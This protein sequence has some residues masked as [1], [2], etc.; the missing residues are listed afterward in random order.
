MSDITVNLKSFQSECVVGE[1]EQPLLC[2]KSRSKGLMVNAC[3]HAVFFC[4]LL[5]AL[6][7]KEESGKV[8]LI[9]SK[10]SMGGEGLKVGIIGGGHAGKQ[11]AR[12]LLELS[13]I[14]VQNI[15]ISTRRPETLSEFQQLGVEC[16]YDNG[17]LVAWAEVVFLCCLP[18]HLLHVCSGIHAALREPCIVYSLVT[19]VPLPRLKQLLSYSAILRP[20][21]QCTSRDL[22]NEWR[23]N[24]TIRAVLQDP[25]VIQATCPCSPKER[26]AVTGKW[27]EAVFYAALNSCMRW[28]LPHQQALKLLND[29]CFP[30]HCPICA[31]Q[32]TS[33]P[34][35]V[36]ENFVNQTFASSL[37]QE[38]T[39]PW[40]DLITVQLKES[41]FSQLLARSVLLQNH[42][43]LLYCTS[44]GFLLAKSGGMASSGIWQQDVS[45]S[46]CS[47]SQLDHESMS[48]TTAIDGT[49][50]EDPRDGPNTDSEASDNI[51][52]V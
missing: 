37:T 50:T 44:F 11:L 1:S 48:T 51:T 27:L 3:A 45:S 43:T 33:C 6:R 32:Q 7:Q 49:R 47:R 26:I 23:T 36:C 10:E 5:Q 31:E 52:V 35:F 20:R 8:S 15:H 9:S 16:F 28:R 19:A 14:S 29:V 41:P 21:Y 34:R 18:S 42:L 24:G 38:D 12:A 22:E 4:K 39:F 25:I 30:E 2:L 17:R 13:G 40:F 46:C